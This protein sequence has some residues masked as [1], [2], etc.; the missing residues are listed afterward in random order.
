MIKLSPLLPLSELV[1]FLIHGPPSVLKCVFHIP[2]H[3]LYTR[4]DRKWKMTTYK[5]GIS[6]MRSRF[7][8]CNGRNLTGNLTHKSREFSG[9]DNTSNEVS[10]WCAYV[11]FTL[12]VLLCLTTFEMLACHQVSLDYRCR[13]G[14]WLKF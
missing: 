2:W 4:K 12:F 8:F 3:S 7:F 1:E 14:S 10:H 6:F 11:I 5:G 13:I 9:I